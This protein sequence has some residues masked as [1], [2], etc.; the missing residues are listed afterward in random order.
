MKVWKPMVG[1]TLALAL[2][3]SGCGGGK[4]DDSTTAAAV[5]RRRPATAAP[6]RS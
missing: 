5:D 6:R 4:K 3:A 2:V 1:A